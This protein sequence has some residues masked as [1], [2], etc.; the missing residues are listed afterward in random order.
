[1]VLRIVSSDLS[2]ISRTAT[3]EGEANPLLAASCFLIRSADHPLSM[4]CF[5]PRRR[6]L[7]ALATIFAALAT[8]A[9]APALTGASLALRSNG[10]SQ[11]SSW[12][13]NDDGYVGTYVT[14]AAPG[15]VTIAVQ[16]SGTAFNGVAPRM[17][18]AVA[19]TVA[20][21]DVAAGL[22]TYEHTFSLPAGTH[23]IRTE[24]N[25]DQSKTSR[26]LTIADLSASS[27]PTVGAALA[28]VNSN[29]NALAAADNY[30]AN[31]R[32]GPAHLNLVGAAPG[33][34]VHVKL[35]QHDFRFGTA[36]GGTNLSGVN[37]FLNNANYTS[38]LLDRFNTVVQGN[39]GKWAYNEAARDV[40]TMSAVDRIF[41][42]AEQNGLNAR[43]HNMIWGD[44]QQPNWA[45]TLLNNANAGNATAKADLRTE[46]SERIDYYVGDG[47]ADT[48][49]GDRARRY[50]EMDLINE[51]DHQ[52][53]YW[54]VYG[55]AGIAD[56]FNE[57]SAAVTAAGSDAR[58]YLNE[59]NVF[60]WGD[61]YGNWYREDADA[62]QAAGGQVGGIGI[63]YYPS[64]TTNASGNHSPARMQSVMQGLSVTGLPLSLTEFG[65]KTEDATTVNQAATYL[66]DTMRMVFGTPNATTFMMWGFWANDVWNQAPLAAL[67]DANWNI[68]A[69]GIAYDQLMS[70]WDTDLML[71]VGPDGAVD[72]TGFYG[73][74][75]VTVDGKPYL[76]SLGKGETN[77]GLIVNLS[78]DF[79]G[80]G[81]VDDADLAAWNQG[82][83][84]GVL[85]GAD[86]L[87]WQQQLGMSESIPSAARAAA[88]SVP[89]PSASALLSLALLGVRRRVRK[90]CRR[91]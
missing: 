51:H 44:S 21:F 71:S 64:A 6:E 62:L 76:V 23:F 41:D 80:D 5:I 4:T 61:A 35:A 27:S 70:Q 73:D 90:I 77:Y 67:F 24:F 63:Q 87:N 81:D 58:L 16:A 85:D 47:D 79:D 10:L 30:V 65:V 91:A 7:I 36:V 31:F 86:L 11:G 69:P 75:E 89:E 46:I 84:M 8:A 55:T 54:N 42:F 53:K 12:V 83:E 48:A 9:E 14:L 74:Y 66:T 28:N 26:A 72:F 19:D 60:Q 15:D 43:L 17:N 49:D 32:K 37:A 18:L 39:A 20:G 33:A 3:M 88:S 57:A 2:E 29:A 34:D 56:M 1:M 68:T 52:P 59:Y 50:V 38:R 82:V 25:N 40:V 78:A 13:L 45:A 22:A